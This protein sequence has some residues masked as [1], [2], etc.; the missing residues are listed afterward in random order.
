[1]TTPDETAIQRDI[2]RTRAELGQT[3]EA[4]A[5]KV[6]VKART[7]EVMAEAKDRVRAKRDELTKSANDYVREFREHPD[8]QLRRAWV[9]VQQSV[10][11]YPKQWA[12]A[13][14]VVAL[15]VLLRAWRRGRK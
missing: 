15:F 8:V 2:E 11:T 10:Q 12:V 9:S 7:Q 6:D 5:A 13:A 3:V 1:M 14:S 4:L